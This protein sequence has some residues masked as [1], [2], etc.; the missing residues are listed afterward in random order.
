MLGQGQLR[1]VF[2]EQIPTPLMKIIL[3][4]HPHICKKIC[5]QNMPYNGGLYGIKSV[6]SRDFYRK[7]GIRTP[8]IWHTNHPFYAI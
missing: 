8:K 1:D 2:R 7:Y 3:T 6:K 5:S 4:P